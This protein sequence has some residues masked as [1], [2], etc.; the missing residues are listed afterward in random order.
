MIEEQEE[1]AISYKNLNKTIKQ[2]LII[3]ISKE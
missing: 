1:G 2:E 3:I